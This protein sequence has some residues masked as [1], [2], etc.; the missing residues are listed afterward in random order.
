MRS[1]IKHPGLTKVSDDRTDVPGFYFA[2][3]LTS[4]NTFYKNFQ[5]GSLQH[6]LHGEK[7]ARA[8]RYNNLRMIEVGAQQYC[9]Y[10]AAIQ[11]G[12]FEE[13]LI[14]KKCS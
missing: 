1:K 12:T 13:F 3:N 5:R 6:Y 2:S 10:Y 14:T 8:Y 7:L 9:K 4:M 11:R